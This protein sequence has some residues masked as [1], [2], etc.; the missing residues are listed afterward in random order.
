MNKKKKE[1]RQWGDGRSRKKKSKQRKGTAID[2]LGTRQKRVKGVWEERLGGKGGVA[3]QK[4]LGRN[5]LLI[6]H[7]KKNSP[8]RE[9]KKGGPNNHPLKVE[10]RDG[11]QDVGEVPINITE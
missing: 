9:K 6:P 11:V 3:N 4:N 2:P 5:S 7:E 1:W 10:T 8:K